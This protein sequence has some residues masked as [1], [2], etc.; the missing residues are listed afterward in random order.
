M[1]TN[2]GNVTLHDDHGHRP[3]ALDGFSCTPTQRLD[4]LAPGASITCTASHTITQADVD[5]G[6]FFN[7]ACVDDGAGGATRGV[8]DVT[9]PGVQNPTL[10]I[11]KNDDGVGLQTR[12]VR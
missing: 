10:T 7:E 6:S 9:T 8:C 4:A 1:A 5:A 2:N 12:S 3:Q 11:T